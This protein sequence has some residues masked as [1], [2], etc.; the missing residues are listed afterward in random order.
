MSAASLQSPARLPSFRRELRVVAVVAAFVALLESYA[1]IRAPWLDYDRQHIHNLP[2]TVAGL[3]SRAAVSGAPRVVFFGNSLILRGLDEPVFHS[4]LATLG[5]SPVE[6]AKIT[7]V[8]TAALDWR[9]LYQRYFS[10]PSSHPD[11][12]VV[13]FLSHHVHDQE[14]VKIRR[15]ARH[16]VA[17]RDFPDLWRTDLRD[18]HQ[19]A[20]S[21]LCHGSAIAGDQPEHQI[22][23]LNACVPDYLDGIRAN[24]RMVESAAARHAGTAPSARPAETFGRLARWLETCRNHGV[25]VYLVA[26]PQPDLWQLNPEVAEIARSHGM[27]VLDARSIDG[28]TA[29]DFSDGYHLGE[30]GAA[31]FSRWLAA[32][33]RDRLPAR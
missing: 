15:L 8:G 7:P 11:V 30:S 17:I 22:A 20:Q 6:S 28:I 10:A 26:M 13:G 9:Y 25:K 18:F 3:E 2:E 14:P 16:F 27:E 31:K 19:I 4:E 32:A 5:G 12:L 21:V 1:R 29:A 33:M 23:M 24:Q